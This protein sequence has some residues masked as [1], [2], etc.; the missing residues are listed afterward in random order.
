LRQKRLLHDITVY[1][2]LALKPPNSIQ[3]AC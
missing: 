1:D 3:I 2:K